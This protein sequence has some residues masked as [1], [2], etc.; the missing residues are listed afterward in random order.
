MRI[1]F[2]SLLRIDDIEKES[3]IYADLMRKFVREGHS[4]TIV[5]PNEKR[6]GL[7]TQYIKG[8]EVSYLRVKTGNITKSNFLEKGIA[9]LMLEFQFKRAISKYL[10]NENFDLILYSTPPITF[11]SVIKYLKKKSSA[12]SYL[13]LKDIFPQ[14]AVDLGLISKRSPIYSFFKAKELRLYHQSDVIGCMSEANVEYIKKNND[15]KGKKVEVC[16]NSIEITP[17]TLSTTK[18]S[19]FSLPENKVIYVYGGNLGKPQGVEF[20][21]KIILKNEEATKS[22][23]CIVGS[24]TEFSNL[25]HFFVENKIKN[26]KLISQLSKEKFDSLLE[27]C[28]VGLIFLDPRFTIPNFP[29]RILSYMEYS[30]PILAATDKVT[31]LSKKIEEGQ[32]GLWCMSGDSTKFFENM[33]VLNESDVR[34]IMGENA[35]KY[36]IE[37]YTVNTSY[38][39]IM[40]NFKGEENV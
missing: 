31:D 36:L 21:K 38:N 30:L 22:F 39:V 18:K 12:R 23:I 15:L 32:F 4:I 10:K 7:A 24:G 19:D 34:Q 3:S 35:Y 6:L 1:V 40:K 9:T 8:T 26:A 37:N 16:P 20:L 13:L 29:S 2:L 14:N 28:D 25:Q 17:K 11:A 5:H 27:I 33:D